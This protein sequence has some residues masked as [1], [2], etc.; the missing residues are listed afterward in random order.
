MPAEAER[1]RALARSVVE[2]LRSA[3]TPFDVNGD[4][5]RGL[6]GLLS[7][8]F[9]GLDGHALVADLALQGYAVGTGSACSADRPEPSRAI[10]ALGRNPRAALGTIRLSFG[11]TNSEETVREFARDLVRTVGRLRVE[12]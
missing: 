1:L 3:G 7:L 4:P 8:S 5:E 11:R 10:L 2:C 9:D 6:P 12:T